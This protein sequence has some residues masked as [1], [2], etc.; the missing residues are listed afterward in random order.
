MG[1]CF[2]T[3]SLDWRSQGK[4]VGMNPQLFYPQ[5]DSKGKI[6]K[7]AQLACKHCPVINQCYDW[8]LRNEVH[9]FWAGLDEKDRKRRQF[10]AGI[11]VRSWRYDPHMLA[12]H[13]SPAAYQRHMKAGEQA[14]RSCLEAHARQKTPDGKGSLIWMYP[15]CQGEE[16]EAEPDTAEIEETGQIRFRLG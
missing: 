5:P 14:C 3:D 9:G 6:P 15:T 2:V 4:C 8:A 7:E 12:P 13:G 1:W 10:A 16:S 11:T